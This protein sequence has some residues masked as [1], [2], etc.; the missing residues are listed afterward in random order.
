MTSDLLRH[1]THQVGDREFA[2]A[3][4][5]VIALIHH[6]ERTHI[7]FQPTE[8]HAT[9]LMARL[10][11]LLKRYGLPIDLLD[12]V[13]SRIPPAVPAAVQAGVDWGYGDSHTAT[14]GRNAS[15]QFY[16]VDEP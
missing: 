12:S 7:V 9:R 8:A 15:G 1:R 16:I 2:L 5:I 10:E 13:E 4:S 11:E 14:L 3:L 6:P